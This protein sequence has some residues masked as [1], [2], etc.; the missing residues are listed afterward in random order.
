MYKG[1][2][3][4]RSEG[5]RLGPKTRPRMT[6]RFIAAPK[7]SSPSQP[8]PTILLS[9]DCLLWMAREPRRITLDNALMSAVA[10][11]CESV[12]ELMTA[13]S[14][15]MENKVFQDS[16]LPFANPFCFMMIL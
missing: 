8:F 6:T 11:C 2:E 12:S 7:F 10:I 14:Y 16:F 1:H 15:V 9:S 13:S 4:M 5:D 3:S